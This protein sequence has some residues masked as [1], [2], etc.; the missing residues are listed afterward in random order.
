[1]PAAV[2]RDRAYEGKALLWY[3]RGKAKRGVICI[4]LYV[5]MCDDLYIMNDTCMQYNGEFYTRGLSEPAKQ[6]HQQ[7]LDTMRSYA[8]AANTTANTFSPSPGAVTNRVTTTTATGGGGVNCRRVFLLRYFGETPSYHRC[9]SCDSCLSHVSFAGD[10]RRD[11][12]L[13][14]GVLLAGLQ[15]PSPRGFTATQL[16]AKVMENS[17][18]GAGGAGGLRQ[19]GC[20]AAMRQQLLAKYTRVGDT[21]TVTLKT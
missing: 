18:A 14:V 20:S 4:L 8:N 12:G 7:A 11:F 3:M 15:F 10:Q 13:E 16:I 1:M 2:Q 21:K 17:S 6:Q 9:G 5:C 19:S